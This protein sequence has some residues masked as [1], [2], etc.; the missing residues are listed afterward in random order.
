MEITTVDQLD[1]GI[2]ARMAD[3]QRLAFLRM[4]MTGAVKSHPAIP[5]PLRIRADPERRGALT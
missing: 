4:M 5:S 2:T 1:Y 3:K